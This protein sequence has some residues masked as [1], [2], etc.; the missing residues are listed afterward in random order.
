MPNGGF[1]C[2]FCVFQRGDTCGLREV[3][4]TN[5]HYTVCPNVTYPDPHS[6]VPRQFH[7]WPDPLPKISGSIE[8]ITSSEGA[9]KGVP[10]LGNQE[11]Q[12]NYPGENS[13]VECGLEV[14]DS[15]AIEWDAELFTFCS[16]KHYLTW[17]NRMILDR[18]ID[19]DL[20]DEEKIDR[21]FKDITKVPIVARFSTRET[22]KGANRRETLEGAS[23][24]LIIPLVFA[25]LTLLRNL[26]P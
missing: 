4:I 10:W 15:R 13:C 17:R 22:R 19:D 8:A 14:R 25:A 18:G 1:G 23:K 6:W 12:E 26:L 16:F 7:P 2:A 9:Y 24:F 20:Y 5:D 11:I 3:R 21:Y